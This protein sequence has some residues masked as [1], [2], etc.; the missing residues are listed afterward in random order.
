[1][2]KIKQLLRLIE[3]INGFKE[4]YKQSIPYNLNIID[5]L[6]ANE[7]AHSRIF[8]KILEY[9][10]ENRFP[11]LYS[12]MKRLGINEDIVSPQF[13]VEKNRID[14]LIQDKNYAIIIEN[15]INNAVDQENQIKRYVDVVKQNYNIDK[16]YVL[17]LTR[18]GE[19]KV[20]ES[21]LPKSLRNELGDRYYECSFRYNILPWLE[22]DTLPFCKYK[23]SILISAIQQYI[24]HLKGQF[25]MRENLSDMGKKLEKII[26]KEFNLA[27]NKIESHKNVDDKIIEVQEILDVLHSYRKKQTDN[28][29]KLFFE[30]FYKRLNKDAKKWETVVSVHNKHTMN[31]DTIPYNFG[32]RNIEENLYFK[33]NNDTNI[34]LS[35][36][37]QEESRILCGF[38]I[39]EDQSLKEMLLNKLEEK[40]EGRELKIDHTNYW[41]HI[42]FDQYVPNNK[43]I[44]SN[45]YDRQLNKLLI[46]NTDYLI[47]L[48][49]KKVSELSEIWN[50]IC[51]E[52]KEK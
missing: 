48:F 4:K 28:L 50:E 16:I 13:S 31:G 5:E 21:S 22:E 11:F 41:I 9:K 33:Y 10:D 8:T 30:E 27:S 3:N 39:D 26:V 14:S 34:F 15:K 32:F 42:K 44:A 49:Y 52:N 37:I 2:E 46:E 38:F 23:E 12:F 25:L 20:T 1:M 36:E 18:F 51:K 40:L 43:E 19:K 45:F 24:D 29:R 17:Y 7:N 6:R 35:I 47:N